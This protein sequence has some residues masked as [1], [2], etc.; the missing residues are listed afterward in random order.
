M[1]PQLRDA[2]ARAMLAV[3]MGALVI[4]GE[5][6]PAADGSVARPRKHAFT[7]LLND[8]RSGRA[9]LVTFR[10]DAGAREIKLAAAERFRYAGGTA[11][12]Q[13]ALS[14]APLPADS[15]VELESWLADWAATERTRNSDA[16]ETACARLA[17]GLRGAGGMRARKQAAHGLWELACVREN[18]GA[19]PLE[20]LDALAN[21]ARTA[22]AADEGEL[23]VLVASAGWMLAEASAASRA[24]LPA[25]EL[26]AAIVTYLRA[27]TADDDDG[28]LDG[29]ERFLPDHWVAT[30][31]GALAAFVADAGALSLF[32]GSHGESSLVPLLG[33]SSAPLRRATTAALW[34]AC[35]SSTQA[36]LQLLSGPGV[37]RLLRLADSL[38]NAPS[39]RHAALL[40]TCLCLQDVTEAM[41]REGA[42]APGARGLNGQ[43]AMHSTQQGAAHS[44]Y[45]SAQQGRDVLRS[46]ELEPLVQAV[47]RSVCEHI[48]NARAAAT[49]LKRSEAAAAAALGTLSA[50]GKDGKE[51][52]RAAAAGGVSSLGVLLCALWALLSCLRATKPAATT[53]RAYEIA[54]VLLEAMSLCQD[55]PAEPAVCVTLCA[56]C[57][58]NLSFAPDAAAIAA[59]ASNIINNHL[60]AAAKGA[61]NDGKGAGGSRGQGQLRQPLAAAAIAIHHH[62][63]GSSLKSAANAA[64]GA[65]H[66]RIGDYTLTLLHFYA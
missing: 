33:H 8:A 61:A 45:N 21:A 63:N 23:L 38:E 56:G 2:L 15:A 34:A 51:G 14:L 40:L 44:S 50:E 64:G 58:A 16:L 3:K 42:A 52:K 17:A 39:V 36:R 66:A 55:N 12:V 32:I 4:G 35:A 28:I 46:L 31:T 60:A 7:L 25:A 29:H 13:H 65:I 41:G 1:P 6:R 54:L 37:A 22:V 27:H 48:A 19:V 62:G 43:P 5:P 11:Y 26:T 9:V 59:S 18:A 10:P 47:T 57:L 20:L 30:L 24:R 49:L 53:A